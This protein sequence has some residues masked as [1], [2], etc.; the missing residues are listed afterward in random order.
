MKCIFQHE[1]I[2]FWLTEEW[3]I[4][5][6]VELSDHENSAQLHVSQKGGLREIG[7]GWVRT[8]SKIPVEVDVSFDTA[9]SFNITFWPDGWSWLFFG[10]KVC[11]RSKNLSSTSLLGLILPPT[12]QRVEG[13]RLSRLKSKYWMRCLCFHLFGP[14]SNEY[15]NELDN[16]CDNHM[17]LISH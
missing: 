17:E 12:R 16:Y 15:A 10:K 1:D 9:L 7:A 13:N 14:L 2:Y 5:C 3:I 6:L 8:A 4:F 11:V